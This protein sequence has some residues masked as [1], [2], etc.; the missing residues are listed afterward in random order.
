MHLSRNT[1]SGDLISFNYGTLSLHCCLTCL[2]CRCN[3]PAPPRPS[4]QGQYAGHPAAP[5]MRTSTLATI[6]YTLA[7]PRA[8]QETNRDMSCAGDT[9]NSTHC[10]EQGLKPPAAPCKTPKGLHTTCRT[11]STHPQPCMS[12]CNTPAQTACL[13]EP[14][15]HPSTGLQDS[16]CMASFAEADLAHTHMG[17]LEPYSQSVHMAAM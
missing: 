1:P 7:A 11:T 16:L 5:G 17:P 6:A 15:Q 8:L 3:H 13:H 9:H 2:H 4:Q 10:H 12:P 14:F